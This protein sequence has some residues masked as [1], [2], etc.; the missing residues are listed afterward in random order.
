MG[1]EAIRKILILALVGL[2]VAES[3][4][5]VISSKKIENV[6]S[7]SFENVIVFNDNFNDNNKDD[8]KWT[9]IYNEGEWWER[10][11]RAE[12]RLYEGGN[13]REGIES[14]EFTVSLST[15]QSVIF[16]VDM[17][18]D[19]DHY[20][21]WQFVGGLCMEIT[22][23]TNYIKAT[24]GR[25]EDEL[26]FRDS[27][28]DTYTIL[29]DFIL[30]HE[31]EWSNTIQVFSNKYM[32]EMDGKE[33]GWIHDSIFSDNPTLTVR[34]YIE[35]SGDYEDFWWIAGFDN[36]VVEGQEVRWIDFNYFSVDINDILGIS[37][38]IF[39]DVYWVMFWDTSDCP[40][41]KPESYNW[42]LDDNGIWDTG[43]TRARVS[44][45]YLHSPAWVRHRIVCPDGTPHEIR[46]ECDFEWG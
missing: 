27:N 12:F 44:K 7:S 8:T 42:D 3:I 46:K 30:D 19:I 45:I 28:D 34:I 17:I 35:L 36:V 2:F 18:S 43:K 23:G 14:S 6:S 15:T 24:F 21:S 16:T 41:G 20:E 1:V 29:K 33:S 4:V 25:H 39:P 13:T 26:K 5:S 37:D 9:E 40:G 38:Y 10:N 11:Q 22:D 31:G 32:V